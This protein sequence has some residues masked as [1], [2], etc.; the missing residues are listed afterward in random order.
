MIEVKQLTGS[1]DLDSSPYKIG[2]E[3]YAYGLNITK[4]AIEGS[5]D[6]SITNIVGNQLVDNPYLNKYYQNTQSYSLYAVVW[7][8]GDNTQTIRVT[9][10]GV[11]A[12]AVAVEYYSSGVWTQITTNS[13]ASGILEG[14]FPYG[15]FQ[16]RFVVYAPSAT[17]YS[18][19]EFATTNVCIG[20]ES[21]Y[22]TMV[23]MI[24]NSEGYSQ[25]LEFNIDTRVIVPIFRNL[26]DSNNIDVLGFTQHDKINNINIYNREEGG[27]LYFLDSLDRPTYMNIERMKALEYVPVTREILDAQVAPPLVPPTGIYAN[28][29]VRK[30]NNCRNK[31]FR[32]K[33]R[34]V[35]DDNQ[36]SVYSPISS[37]P[38]PLNILDSTY[39]NV[40]TNNN[41]IVV[42][43]NS[44]AK[45][46]KDIELCV[47]I[48]N[49]TNQWLD[50]A[51]V[52]TINKTA[53]SIA[54]DVVF[55]YQ[56][57]NDSTYPVIDI[58]ESILLYD[59]LPPYAKAQEMPNGNVLMYGAI[60]EG[61]DKITNMNVTVTVNTYPVSGSQQ[62][63]LTGVNTFMLTLLN[64]TTYNATFSGTPAIGTV[65]VLN[66]KRRSDDAFIIGAT[67]TTVLNDTVTTIATGLLASAVGLG[68]FLSQASIGI[69]L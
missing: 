31:L 16:Y 2:K 9:F 25:V 4:D 32:F 68:I 63:T 7:N 57:Y 40:V 1:L 36:K 13:G 46:V 61:Y 66:L 15:D 51:L 5:N 54:D 20:S 17:Y 64:V 62:G 28:D 45:N 65:I 3:D 6:I 18:L 55:S 26:I 12:V 33:Y 22:P 58:A 59:Y 19:T 44:G 56:F 21:N 35:Y 53:S 11:S 69:G 38:L 50:F 41:N 10:T 30:V 8:N 48:C 60:R 39:T 47:S 37:V 42:Q 67:Y 43:L 52:E 34:W 27:L 23:Y 29:T 24:W 14:T 49:K